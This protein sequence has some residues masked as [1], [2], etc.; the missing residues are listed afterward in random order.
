MRERKEGTTLQDSSTK[1]TMTTAMLVII[2]AALTE[3]E[4]TLYQALC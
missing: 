1:D 2:V 4:H 3:P